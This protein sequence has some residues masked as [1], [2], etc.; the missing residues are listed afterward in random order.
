[1]K[2]GRLMLY[3]SSENNRCY[4]PPLLSNGD[5]SFAPDAE[6]MLGYSLNDCKERGVQAF[7]GIVVRAARRSA[8][9][10]SLHARLFPFGKFTFS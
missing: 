10:N 5:I 8:L 1:M 7:D 9:C 6:G 3:K 2:R 4:F